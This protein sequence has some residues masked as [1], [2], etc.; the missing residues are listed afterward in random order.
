MAY[1]PDAACMAAARAAAGDLLTEQ[2]ILKAFEDIDSYKTRLEQQGIS[3]G[4]A[5]RLRQYA[6][7]KGERTKLAAALARKQAALNIIIRDK[8]MENIGSL[9]QAGLTPQQAM[10]AMLEGS[11][12]GVKNARK[13]V[14]AERQ[15]FE[16]IYLG[17]MMAE[18]QRTH[19]HLVHSMDDATLDENV[20]REMK[21]LRKDGNPGSTGDPDAQFL[22]MTFSKWAEMMRVDL[23][24]LGANIGKLDDWAGPQVH[25]PVKLAAVDPEVWAAR[26]LP[27]LD[28]ERTFPDGPTSREALGILRDIHSTIITGI[29]PNV[30]SNAE[31]GIRVSPANMANSLASHRVLHF[32]DADAV[33][34]YRSDFGYGNTI[35]G[36]FS[37]LR[38]MSRVGA[39]MTVFGPNPEVMFTSISAELQRRIS[40]SRTLTGDEKMRLTQGL[41]T[42]TGAL[43]HA[44]DIAIGTQAIP[45]SPKWADIGANIR[46]FQS[47]SKLGGAVISSITDPIAV[48]AS[49]QFRGAKFFPTFADQLSMVMSGRPKGEAGEVGFLIGEGFDGI[50]GH[51]STAYGAV[52]G[53]PGKMA[54][55][56]DIFFK[57]NGLTWWTD[58][59][60]SAAGRI[61]SAEMGMRAQSSHGSLPDAYKHVLSLHGID[62]MKWEIIREA[63]LRQV[64]GH[65]YVT[66]DRI[67]EIDLESFAP[68]AA[69]RIASLD[70]TRLTLQEYTARRQRYLEDARSGLTH[71]VARFFADETSFGMIETDARS[72]RTATW[73]TRPGTLAGE[74]IRFIM[75]F[76]GW[77]IA[78]TQRVLGRD[79]FGRRPGS[80]NM[81][82]QTFWA[83]TAPH[84]GTLLVGL[85]MAGYAAMTVKDAL[86][87][88]TPRDLG[89]PRTWM[90]AF[91]QGGAWGIYS[92][93][94]FSS[95]NRFGGGLF[96]T[97]A[98]PTIG[99]VGDLWAI[100]SDARDAALTGGEDPFSASKTFSTLWANVPGANL[101]Y[102]K[103][104]VD[105][106]FLNSLRETLSPGYLRAQEQRRAKEY[107]QERMDP[108]GL[109]PTLVQ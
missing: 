10:L 33:L 36:M 78:F 94:L 86:K 88:Y 103:P 72:R 75:Q 62:E 80:W 42:D 29:S 12:R 22:A 81:G 99:T 68:L 87:G 47:I 69:N 93:F 4:K 77:P 56:Q 73:G 32:K 66:P 106:L 8:A 107:G 102:V 76:K 91:Q 28:V 92:D 84:I 61:I 25:D 31:K 45:G 83:E 64:N 48:A 67:A 21:E 38:S 30:L 44:L 101:F 96:E 82:Q 1:T 51:I 57:L 54:R 52:D 17:G 109:G 46:I 95:Q 104:A 85:T 35:A 20:L 79:L 74:A 65:S 58:S 15:A 34:A 6:I 53:V 13:S 11:I 23:N 60:R 98:G 24:R 14:A 2:D 7:E 55:L 105:F 40:A 39:N 3:T 108:L 26:I 16:A 100:G 49:A 27:L 70:P 41:K 43:R 97:L 59:N 90:A 19:P 50:T 18:I 9:M 63:N 89:D 71:D 37:H 5:A